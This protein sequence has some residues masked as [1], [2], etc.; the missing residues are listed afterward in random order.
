M[1]I[2]VTLSEPDA[3]TVTLK[4]KETIDETVELKARK[5]LNG[6]IMIYDHNEI[7]IVIMPEKQ[8]ILTFA[9]EFYGDQV[10][11]AQ[12]RLFNFLRKRGIIEYDSI[13]GGNIYYSMEAS[14]QESEQY[15]TTQHAL[16][17]VSR[18]LEKERPLMAFEK[19]FEEQE[20]ARLNEPP[21]GEFTEYDPERFHGERRGS[22]NTAHFPYGIQT[23]AIYRLEE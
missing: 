22:M 4:N 18:F 20:E 14:I 11:E 2:K 5:S 13:T 10:Y 12:N 19:S 21:P 9:K 17:A 7:D 1:A 3:I 23:A 16:L 8:K 6:D 15:N